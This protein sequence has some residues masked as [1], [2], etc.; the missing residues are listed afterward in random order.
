MRLLRRLAGLAAPLLV[1]LLGQ[2]GPAGAAEPLRILAFGDSLTAGYGLSPR[3]AFPSVL[4]ERLRAD[5]YDVTIANAGVPGDTTAMGLKRLPQALAARPDLVILELGANDMLN[6]IGPRV[7]RANLER[8]ISLCQGQGARVLLAGMR[9][10]NDWP[11]ARKAKFD[12]IFPALAAK[13]RLPFY[14]FFLEGVFG[15]ADLLLWGGPHPNAA[16]VRIIVDR[17]APLVERTLQV[18]ALRP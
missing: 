2:S 11:A 1:G 14:P 9:A 12:A 18:G 7:T 5:G 6:D 13:H 4:A 10:F 8:M 15:H 17:I 3:E 16:G